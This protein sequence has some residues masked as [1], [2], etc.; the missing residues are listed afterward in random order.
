MT[1]DFNYYYIGNWRFSRRILLMQQMLINVIIILLQ[2]HILWLFLSNYSHFTIA[3]HFR[4]TFVAIVIA[5][6]LNPKQNAQ[7]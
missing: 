4:H 6:E 1:T 3:L 5:F 7:R 2:M